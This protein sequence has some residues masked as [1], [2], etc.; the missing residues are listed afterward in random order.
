VSRAI[1]SADVFHAIADANRR[2]LLDAMALRDATVGELVDR[3]GLSYS[4]VSEHLA[5]LR[6]AGLVSSTAPGRERL[7][8]LTP[9]PLREVHQWSGK[10][11]QFWR[12]RLARL[13]S[14]LEARKR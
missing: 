3:V 8:R 6:D 2:A 4:A 12:G 13:R 5:V 14:V 9:Q 1:A 11:E 10:N 7:Y